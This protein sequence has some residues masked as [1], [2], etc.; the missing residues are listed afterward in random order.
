MR[1]TGPIA[2]SL[3]A[4]PARTHPVF[5]LVRTREATENK[6]PLSKTDLTI[7]AVPP[8]LPADPPKLPDSQDLEPKRARRGPARI[9]FTYKLNLYFDS[10]AF[11]ELSAKLKSEPNGLQLLS[12]AACSCRSRRYYLWGHRS[13][14]RL[15]R[16]GSYPRPSAGYKSRLMAF[17]VFTRK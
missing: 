2:F 8:E 1:I 6:R 9:P 14:P 15:R 12:P 3:L 13:R 10:L 11:T 7:P 17:F 4:A 16:F 5:F